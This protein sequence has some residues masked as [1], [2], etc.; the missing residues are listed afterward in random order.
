MGFEK[1]KI[2]IVYA[3]NIIKRIIPNS[4]AERA[5]VN[6]GWTIVKVNNLDQPDDTDIIRK[7]IQKTADNGLKTAIAFG[8]Q[9]EFTINPE[10]PQRKRKRKNRAKNSK[11]QG[12]KKK[13]SKKQSSKKQSSKKKSLK[14]KSSK[15]QNSKKQSSEKNNKQIKKMVRRQKKQLNTLKKLGISYE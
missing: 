12:S 13:S 8:I 15:K 1:K 11:K 4:Q 5:K 6:V 2:G 9:K 10:N 14:E 7:S 3:G